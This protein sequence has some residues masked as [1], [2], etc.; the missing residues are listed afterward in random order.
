MAHPCPKCEAPVP[1]DA[2]FC[3]GCGAS[4]AAPPL[5]DTLLSAD[6]SAEVLPS[7]ELAPEKL[8]AALGPNYELGRLLGRGGYAEVFTV[9]DLRLERE[10]AVK[11]LRPDLILSEQLIGRFRREALA[12]GA[13]QNPNIVPVYDVGESDGVLWILM[14]LIQGETLKSILGREGHLP[15][16]EVRRILLEAAS[17]LHAAHQAGVIHRDIK[18]ENLMIEGKTG[19]VM[20]MDFGIAKAIDAGG[21]H[22]LTGTGVIVG[23]PKYMS[24]EQA[25]GKQALTAATDQYS[26]AV[27]GYQMLS[28]RVPFEGDNV[29]EV[30]TRQLFDEPVPLSRMIPDIPPDVSATIHRALRKD[31]ARRFASVEGFARAL[32]GEAPDPADTGGVRR[33]QSQPAAPG[34][35][36]GWI[37]TVVGVMVLAGG[38]YGAGKAGVFK[39]GG[40]SPAPPPALPPARSPVDARSAGSPA[41]N[42]TRT[43]PSRRPA[44]GTPGLTRDT[45]LPP[46]PPPA[47]ATSCGQAMARE[48]WP[49][50][51]TRCSAEKDSSSAARRNLGIL[52]AE[53]KGVP[54]DDRRATVYLSLAA[55]DEEL[56]DT[57][58]VVLAAQRYD[59]GLGVPGGPDRNKGS[60]FWEMAAAMGYAAAWPI[61][62]E[63]YATGDGRRKNEAAAVHWYTKAAELG[64]T[65]SMLRLA[66]LLD[67]GQ[68]VKKDEVAAGHWYN[69]AAANRDP[70]GEYQ[71]AIR[72]LNGKGGFVK[73]EA[74]GMEWLRRAASHGHSEAAKELA[75]RGG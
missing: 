45:A 51:F 14:P 61:I 68:G 19:R 5:D 18:P 58:A 62:A 47:L 6:R 30:M 11:V 66:E 50:A 33:R 16:E 70:E 39:G 29:R 32:R 73:D 26:L 1:A 55:Q 34:A 36:R 12:V 35:G 28:G 10:L 27:V 20:L 75:R 60:G 74:R 72:L 8:Q 57:Q 13:V 3:P 71:I 31:P 65:P 56:P 7:Y 67:R 64:H 21:E 24:P 17:A 48:D 42:R 25:T 53:G 41:E 2:A 54:K 69:E 59:A 9:R 49:T 40:P 43:S 15:V 46:P 38:L 44:G 52:Y 63:R 37:K 23:T 4:T 22:S